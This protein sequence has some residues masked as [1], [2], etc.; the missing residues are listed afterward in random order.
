MLD[1]KGF[2][3]F[4]LSRVSFVLRSRKNSVGLVDAGITCTLRP[5]GY[6]RVKSNVYDESR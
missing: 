4:G 2:S 5:V 3:P 1:V 6:T